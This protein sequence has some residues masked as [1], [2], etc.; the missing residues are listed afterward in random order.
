[1]PAESVVED[2]MRP[3]WRTRREVGIAILA[4]RQHGLVS[5]D[6]LRSAGLSPRAIGRRIDAAR[7]HPVHRGVY[8][9]GHR[10][11]TRAGYWMAGVLAGGEGAVLSHRSAG[12]LWELTGEAGAVD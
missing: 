4:E 5:H 3:K 11:L 9:V 2:A 7:L 6:Q 10:R 1:M 8:A 12:A